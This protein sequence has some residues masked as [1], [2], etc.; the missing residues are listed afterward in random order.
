MEHRIPLRVSGVPFSLL[1]LQCR[2]GDGGGLFGADCGMSQALLIPEGGLLD[3]EFTYLIFDD[4]PPMITV[5][6]E[7]SPHSPEA[8]CGSGC[9]A[10]D[11]RT[12]PVTRTPL[13]TTTTTTTLRLITN[14]GGTVSDNQTGLMWEQKTDDRTIHDKD[15]FYNWSTGAPW[16]PDGTVYSNF[17]GELNGPSPF[18]GYSDWRLPT[19]EE[20]ASIVDASQPGP[21]LI[22]QSAFG[23]TQNDGYWS[24]TTDPGDPSRA[25]RV[26]FLDGVTYTDNKTHS[27]WVRAVRTGS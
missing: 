6:V 18:A 8:S 15:N 13:S 9:T 16:S 2:D 11:F 27:N 19:P 1:N 7:A 21:P 14:G 22:D 10:S 17:L 26:Y 3:T 12:F 23:P 4:A 20:L 24:G 5:T 25:Y